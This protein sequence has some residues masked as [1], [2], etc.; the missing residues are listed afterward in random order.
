MTEESKLILEKLN[1]LDT[2]ILD[3]KFVL[4]QI[5]NRKIQLIA[6]GH[7]DLN[8]NSDEILRSSQEKEMLLLRVNRLENDMRQVKEKINRIA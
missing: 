4:E 5:T 8:K 7:F 2:K 6:E 1:E 3:L